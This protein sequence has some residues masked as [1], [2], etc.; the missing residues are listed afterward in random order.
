MSDKSCDNPKMLHSIR[1][2]SPMGGL[3]E[4]KDPNATI[5]DYNLGDFS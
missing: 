1:L 5:A 3:K 4:L 2:V